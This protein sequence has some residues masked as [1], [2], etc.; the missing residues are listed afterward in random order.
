MGSGNM[1]ALRPAGG[2]AGRRAEA[3]GQATSKL[4]TRSELAAETRLLSRTPPRPWFPHLM[5][6]PNILSLSG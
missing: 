1:G 2:V 5:L 3:D 4:P 6:Y